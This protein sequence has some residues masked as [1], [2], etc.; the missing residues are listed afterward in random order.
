MATP[1]ERSNNLEAISNQRRRQQQPRN[2]KTPLRIQRQRGGDI[3]HGPQGRGYNAMDRLAFG[4]AAANGEE[5]K[6]QRKRRK[7][8]IRRAPRGL[9]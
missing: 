6:P 2:G 5:W 7:G 9:A 1:T 8:W 4:S 3:G